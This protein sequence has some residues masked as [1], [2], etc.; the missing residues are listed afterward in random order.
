MWIVL[1]EG[2]PFHASYRRPDYEK[3]KQRLAETGRERFIAA[4]EE[5]RR[6]DARLN[7]R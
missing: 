2:G 1:R 5:R 7:P 3:Y 4:L 6:A